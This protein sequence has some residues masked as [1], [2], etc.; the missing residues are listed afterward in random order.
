MLEDKP[1][2]RDNN[3]LHRNIADNA[4]NKFIRLLSYKTKI[5]KTNPNNT[6][7]EC[8]RC[9]NI[10]EMDLDNRIYKCSKWFSNR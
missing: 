4:F 2:L 10:Q 9:S 8:Y 7:K 3:T 5:I 1:L 6:T